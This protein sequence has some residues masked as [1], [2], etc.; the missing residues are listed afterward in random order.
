MN[1]SN[2]ELKI[3]ERLIIKATQAN[4]PINGTIELTPLCNMNCNMCFIRVNS[5]EMHKVGKL[6]SADE[7]LSVASQMKKAGT[8][9]V[10]ISGGEPLLHPDFKEI[11]LGLLDLGM[12][13]TINTNGTLIN[14]EISE[15]FRKHRPRRINVTLYGT[16]NETYKKLCHNPHGFDQAIN[17]IKLLLKNNI[18]VKLNGTIVPENQHEINNFIKIANDFGLYMKMDTY[19]YPSH[20]ERNCLFQ[21]ESRLTAKK[22]ALKSIEIKK[23]QKT[24]TE[25]DNYKTM[26]LQKLNSV[27]YNKNDSINCRAGK[28]AFWITW[29]GKLTPCVF[30]NNIGLDVFKNDFNNSWQYLINETKKLHLPK[31]C[32]NCSK[33]EVCQVCLAAVYCETN[34]F[35]NEPQYMCEYTKNILEKLKMENSN[36]KS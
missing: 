9:F 2:N 33:K 30:I 7:W 22:A 28:S 16:C 27:A 17:G 15:L 21:E 13:V 29:Y 20:R 3:E 8:L 10:L 31:K 24:K 1:L 6:K 25:Y 26:V 12:I 36:E 35:D 11:Y 4:I 32:L 34:S 19:I 14:E 18:D 5:E 23:K